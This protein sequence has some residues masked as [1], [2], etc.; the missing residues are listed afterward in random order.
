MST[1][2]PPST[3]SLH[4]QYLSRTE[5]CVLDACGH[6]N[7]AQFHV[8]SNPA[9]AQTGG[10]LFDDNVGLFTNCGKPAQDCGRVLRQPAL[11]TDST[12]RK[13]LWKKSKALV[14]AYSTP[15]GEPWQK[16]EKANKKQPQADEEAPQAVDEERLVDEDW[17]VAEVEGDWGEADQQEADEEIDEEQ[18]FPDDDADEL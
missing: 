16:P 2:E 9:L 1:H 15:L 17:G 4:S 6:W 3:L 10:H 11:A 18:F 12:V 14:K 7:A 8:A 13:A 5:G